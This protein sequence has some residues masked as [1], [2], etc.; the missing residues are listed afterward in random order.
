MDMLFASKGIGI[1]DIVIGPKYKNKATKSCLDC[2]DVLNQQSEY[3]GLRRNVE[4]VLKDYL[5]ANPAS[6]VWYLKGNK[7]TGTPIEYTKDLNF[8]VQKMYQAAA[9]AKWQQKQ[10][11][12][13]LLDTELDNLLDDLL[14]D[15]LDSDDDLLDDSDSDD[16]LL[17]GDGD[18][19]DSGDDFLLDDDNDG[20]LT[21]ETEALDEAEA[22][23]D[24][25]G[26]RRHHSIIIETAA[27]ATETA[28]A[29]A[30]TA[31]TVEAVT[32]TV[33]AEA[34][35]KSFTVE[36][37]T[38]PWQ[39]ARNVAKITAAKIAAAAA[40]NGSTL[41]QQRDKEGTAVWNRVLSDKDRRQK[42]LDANQKEKQAKT[43]KA[44]AKKRA[45]PKTSRPKAKKTRKKMTES[46]KEES[47]K[48]E[49]ILKLLAQVR[50]QKLQPPLDQFFKK[51][52][53]GTENVPVA[54]PQSVEDVFAPPS[55]E[56]VLAAG[57]N[58]DPLDTFV[59]EFEIRN[60]SKG[61]K[62]KMERTPEYLDGMIEDLKKHEEGL[63]TR[64]KDVIWA[65][66][67]RKY[68]EEGRDLSTFKKELEA[69]VEAVQALKIQSQVDQHLKILRS[70]R[71][72]FDRKLL[73]CDLKHKR[74]EDF[75]EEAVTHIKLLNALGDRVFEKL[76][77]PR[78]GWVRHCREKDEF[79][80]CVASILSAGTLDT[81]LFYVIVALRQLGWLN[82]EFM[83]NPRHYRWIK[84]VFVR[85]GLN[86]FTD[87]AANVCGF[88]L[89]L[90]TEYGGKV[91]RD[92]QQLLSFYGIGRKIYAL[93]CH[94]VFHKREGHIIV[95][96]HVA[97]SC[98][99]FEWT[100]VIDA[101]SADAIAKEVEA[102]MPSDYYYDLN[103]TFA[104]IRQ[105]WEKSEGN[106]KV[107]KELA[108]EMGCSTLVLKLCEGVRLQN[109]N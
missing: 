55:P 66:V 14:D 90:K 22:L 21:D 104:G 58:V 65:V 18:L 31:V 27:A 69:E 98:I 70:K 60:E 68:K 109:N 30:A 36:A 20:I 85:V 88:A 42:I 11:P 29:E 15:D 26:G 82:I 47:Q 101:K 102:W 45:P 23:P 80:L 19:D 46:E 5:A 54:P 10:K 25:L 86:Y 72:V 84:A 94:D 74:N 53:D 76:S 41:Q 64:K 50:A 67:Q 1:D 52:S 32:E 37:A 57:D 7:G 24:L 78:D 4:S 77:A 59:Q 87:Q 49:T 2:L 3:F 39:L 8:V 34:A 108:K 91:P 44:K 83:S 48:G 106:R 75:V 100:K 81:R 92:P 103:R 105:L 13:I 71:T 16:D 56:E 6:K 17:D 96:V 62:L 51:K 99:N 107:I 43:K 93:I 97:K 33:T 28:A 89:R 12:M 63:K 35:T 79:Q 9:Q 95:D 38:D 61:G 73:L 40:A